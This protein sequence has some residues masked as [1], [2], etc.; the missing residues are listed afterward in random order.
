VLNNDYAC[1]I[2]S[3]SANSQGEFRLE[4]ITPG[5]YVVL[6]L[7]VQGIEARADPVSF[8]VVDQDVSALVVKPF[9]FLPLT[10]LLWC[11]PGYYV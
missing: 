1:V 10:F 4:N 2:A 3:V 9:E 7:P 6:L 5:K 8:E 11:L